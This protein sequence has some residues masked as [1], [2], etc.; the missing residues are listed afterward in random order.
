V[1]AQHGI[2]FAH[3]IGLQGVRCTQQV[4]VAHRMHQVRGIRGVGALRVADR[5]EV[6]AE[7][8]PRAR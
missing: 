3:A 2:G 5:G 7:R 4:G 1:V 6:V 8:E